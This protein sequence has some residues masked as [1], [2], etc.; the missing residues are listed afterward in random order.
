[1]PHRFNGKKLLQ[2]E[3]R[4]PGGSFTRAGGGEVKACRTQKRSCSM[5]LVLITL[6]SLSLA[7]CVLKPREAGREA[8][9]L[10]ATGER[11]GYARGS[12]GVRVRAPELPEQPTWRDVLRR[13]F[14]ANGDL[15]AAYHE[16]A[17]AVERIDQAGTWPTSNLELGFEY[18]FSAE[19]MKAFDRTTV[20]VGLMDPSALPNK[21]F[22]NAKVATHEAQA[23]GERFRAAKFELQMRVLQAWADYA[24]QAEQARINQENVVLLRMVAET[25]ASRVRTGGPQQEQLRADVELRMA[26]NELETSKATLDQQRSRLNALLLRETAAPI[27]P[28]DPM[29]AP[30]KVAATD[31]ALLAAGVTNNADLAALGWDQEARRTAIE[32][33]RMEYLPEINPM[34]AFTGSVSQ[35]VGATIGLPTQLPRIR[36]MVA[37]ARSDLRRLEAMTSQA[38]AD[39]AGR[40]AA[41]LLAMR[42]AERRSDVFDRDVLPLARQ[43]VDL[44][45][46][47]YA[48]G[49]SS[50]LDLIDAQRT[51]LDVRLMSV[52]AR[53]LREKMLAELEA[54]AGMDVET[55][56]TRNRESP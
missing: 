51:L 7:G 17:M 55:L 9:R 36:A 26:E 41:T 8:E 40:F 39:R 5:R 22:Q 48:A 19:R 12:A 52:E 1:M 45:R 46:R 18:M 2:I 43:T 34:A 54:L 31:D 20:S 56:E 16:W 47:S 10:S 53:T 14:L 33:A 25:A 4:T 24:L 44:T 32:R 38:K 35:S 13:A 42:D 6:V 21:T 3:P 50:Y 11:F 49:S 37:E 23:A 30:R 29:P 15:E 27:A 28:P